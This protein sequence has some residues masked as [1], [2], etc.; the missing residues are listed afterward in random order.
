MDPSSSS[1]ASSH[2]LH[3]GILVNISNSLVIWTESQYL[4]IKYNESEFHISGEKFIHHINDPS[5]IIEI[6]EIRYNTVKLRIWTSGILI[7]EITHTIAVEHS[8]L[9]LNNTEIPDDT[10][11]NWNVFY[12]IHYKEYGELI[13]DNIIQEAC[14]SQSQSN[15]NAYS[16]KVM[17]AIKSVSTVGQDSLS[18]I[19]P[20]KQQY[21]TVLVYFPDL[22]LNS[23]TILK[24]R[25]NCD[26]EPKFELN[27]DIPGS[28]WYHKK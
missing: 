16:D 2:V 6:C 17:T 21:K 23:K 15:F 4:K 28:G 8:I 9:L 22:C 10:I 24:L 1:Q 18:K 20:H 19:V 3:S 7:S 27:I 26:E 5:V 25:C 13:D 14:A 11:D 12:E